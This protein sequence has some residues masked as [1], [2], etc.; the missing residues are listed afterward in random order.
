VS[1][2]DLSSADYHALGEFRFQIRRFLH[3]SEEAAKAEGLEPQQHQLLLAIRAS[4]EATGPTISRLAETMTIRHHSAVGLIDRLAERGL[5]DRTKDRSDRRQAR[6]RL[7]A[8]GDAKL[9]R[10]SGSHRD[11][12]RRTGPLLVEALT[13]LLQ[14]KGDDETTEGSGR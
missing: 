7:T 2:P 5:V 3:F 6:I 1:K 10:L 11:E 12:L 9:R 8:E 14:R 13:R 4:G